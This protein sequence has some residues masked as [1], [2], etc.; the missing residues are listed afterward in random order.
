MGEEKQAFIAYFIGKDLCACMSTQKDSVASVMPDDWTTVRQIS[1]QTGFLLAIRTIECVRTD[2]AMW[3]SDG[4]RFYKHCNE[5]YGSPDFP[6]P[7]EVQGAALK[8][9]RNDCPFQ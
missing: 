2:V 1:D 5:S 9:I 8:S 4:A 6:D 3:L 7:W